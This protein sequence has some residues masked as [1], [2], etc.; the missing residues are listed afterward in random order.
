MNRYFTE[1]I[2]AIEA[3]GGHRVLVTFK[4]GF[5]GEVDLTPL[6]ECGPIFEQLR[7]ETI[8]KQVSVAHG[9]PLWPDDLDLSPG[10]LRAWCEAG[11]FMD[12]E[13]TDG[14]IEQHARSPETVA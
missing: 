8:F 1:K 9:A 11:R 10:A 4:D 14:W 13:E 7:D 3:T 6:L 5:V 12:Y 2:T